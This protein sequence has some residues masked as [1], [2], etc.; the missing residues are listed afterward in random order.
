MSDEINYLKQDLADVFNRIKTANPAV[1]IRLSSVFYRDKGDDYLVKPSDF[2]SD[3]SVTQSFLST[4]GA[5]GGGDIPEAVDAALGATLDLKWDDE[6]DAKIAFLLLDAPPHED[7]ATVK[8]IQQYAQ[9]YAKK[10]IKIVPISASGIDKSTEYLMRFLALATNGTYTYLTD[11]SGVGEGHIDATVSDVS[12]EFL[13][14][15]LVRIINQNLVSSTCAEKAIATLQRVEN[16]QTNEIISLDAKLFPV[17]AMEILTLEL[18]ENVGDVTVF[19]LDGKAVL[20]LGKR[21]KGQHKIDI[22]KLASATYFMQIIKN[23]V[24]FGQKFVVLGL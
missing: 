22:S 19:S 11:D 1:A 2:T 14:N 18:S 13:N 17:P 20:S 10:G 23:G 7:A 3:L 12:I 24:M 4:Q 8:M 15:L 5:G 9:A 6:A 16:Q 21:D